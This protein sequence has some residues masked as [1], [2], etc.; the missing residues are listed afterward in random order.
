MNRPAP[1]P[2][3]PGRRPPFPGSIGWLEQL[4]LA[5]HT[6]RACGDLYRRILVGQA[7]LDMPAFAMALRHAGL[8]ILPAITLVA[9]ALGM[10]LGNQTQAV[11]ARLD[12]PG[13]ALLS[14]VYLIVME[15][16]PVLVGILVAGRAG[17]ALAVRQATLGV[18]GEIDG[19]LVQGVDPLSFTVGP[20]L[21]AMLLMSF[22][23]A[24]WTTVV[25][26][27]A[28][29]LWLWNLVGLS[30]ALFVAAL[31]QALTPGDLALAFG[32]PLLFALVIALIAA[33][34]GTLAGR[35]PAGVARAAT[36]TMIGAV[37]A[38]LII[39]LVLVL[40]P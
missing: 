21:L 22:A 5:W 17:V 30:P 10:I 31:Q 6:L 38:I 18:S 34:Q 2:M 35:D 24:V 13:L 15:L 1:R 20:A 8:S 19:L 33:V 23:L 27:L 9:V 4:G 37:V 14:M 36:R 7:R 39:D 16:V 32:K 40:R 3:G 11:L 29:F 12:L 25:T 28:A 26:V